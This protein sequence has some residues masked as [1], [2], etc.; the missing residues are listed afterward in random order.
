MY[1]TYSFEDVTCSFIHP[2]VGTASS[3]GAGMGSI[4]IAMADDKTAH[5]RASDGH[6]MISKIPGKNGTLAVTMQQTSE[7]NKYLLRW[8]NYVD[9]ANSSEFA[10]MVISIKSNNLGDITTCTGVTPQKLAD[11]SYQAQG[12][13][14]TWNLMAAEITES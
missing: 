7:L 13:Q 8:Y 2:G 12:Q 10:K 11:R 6:V 1:S 5:D 14:V 3:S 4:S 9:V